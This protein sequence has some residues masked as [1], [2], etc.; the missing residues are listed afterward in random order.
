MRKVTGMKEHAREWMRE[1]IRSLYYNSEG[2]PKGIFIDGKTGVELGD[3]RF[4]P[5]R[6]TFRVTCT[7]GVEEGSA[8]EELFQRTMRYA[9]YG[10]GKDFAEGDVTFTPICYSGAY[11]SYDLHVEGKALAALKSAVSSPPATDMNRV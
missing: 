4:E 9:V 2:L 1:G 6:T 7:R 8:E 3:V 11:A 10:M 5:T